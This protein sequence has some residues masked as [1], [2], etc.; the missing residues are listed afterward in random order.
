MKYS[1][2]N[3]PTMTSNND[4]QNRVKN[5]FETST[6]LWTEEHTAKYNR[7]DQHITAIMLSAKKSCANKKQGKHE[8]SPDLAAAG[9]ELSYWLILK[10]SHKRRVSE[11]TL[12][13][14]RL[15]ARLPARSML[16]G[17]EL[18]KEI[19]LAQM[20]LEAIQKNAYEHRQSWLESLAISNDFA[21]GK[22][23]TRSRTL[24]QQ[25]SR[26]EWPRRYRRCQELIGTNIGSSLRE[27]HVP[28]D[29]E[30]NPP[31]QNNLGKA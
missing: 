16:E 23:P 18:N 4:I 7:L 17:K 15:R 5:L 11:E 6:E 2:N 25:I 3:S 20:R 1:D 29:P 24:K 13:A 12:E 31:T 19:R 21:R 14:Y 22:D 10:L 26:E 30:E 9:P 8:W 27:V 28:S